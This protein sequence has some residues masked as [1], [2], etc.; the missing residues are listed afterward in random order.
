[1]LLSGFAELWVGLKNAAD[2]EARLDVRVESFIGESPFVSGTRRCIGGL[3][4]SVTEAVKLVVNLDADSPYIGGGALFPP[5]VIFRVSARMGTNEDGS[6]CGAVAQADGVRLYYNTLDRLSLFGQT[7]HVEPD[8]E[9]TFFLRSVPSG[10]DPNPYVEC[11]RPD[12]AAFGCPWPAPA[13]FPHRVAESGELNRSS[14]WKELGAWKENGLT[15]GRTEGSVAFEIGRAD[16]TGLTDLVV[17]LDRKSRADDAARFD[18]SAEVRVVS[19]GS[20]WVTEGMVRCL[21]DLRSAFDSPALVRIP[22]K[23]FDTPIPANEPI[24]EVVL[25]LKARM[26]TTDTGAFCSGRSGS[27]GIRAHWGS[28][29]GNRPSDRQS[30]FRFSADPVRRCGSNRCRSPRGS[31]QRSRATAMGAHKA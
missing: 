18:V 28:E 2:T 16:I 26:G 13:D 29:V 6:P 3:S 21:S 8:P 14:G 12:S 19:Q 30:F 17:W 15:D 4:A 5:D 24:L 11:S 25:V 20:T 7:F 9:A 1:V 23:P 31:E 22:F 27:Q 10:A